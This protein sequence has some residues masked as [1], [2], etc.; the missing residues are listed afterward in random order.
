MG[1]GVGRPRTSAA[2]S[3]VPAPRTDVEARVN[4]E[5]FMRRALEL[6]A[7]AIRTYPNPKV[8]AVVTRYGDVIG[9]GYHRGAGHRHA[10]VEALQG[11]DAAGATMYV[12]LEPCSHQGRTPPCAPAVADAGIKRV[13]VATEDPD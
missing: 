1:E 3:L 2:R 9:E 10:E 11:I 12:T 7:R 13:V 5:V 4:E 8:G 6:A